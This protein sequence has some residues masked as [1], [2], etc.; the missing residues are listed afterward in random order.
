[1][2]DR[3]PAIFYHPSIGIQI[4]AAINSNRDYYKRFAQPTLMEWTRIRATQQF[5]DG[6][7]WFKIFL[8]DEEVHSVVN[9]KARTYWDMK[10]YTSSDWYP[11]QP[12]TIR[13]LVILSKGKFAR[14]NKLSINLEIQL[15]F[16]S[17]ILNLK[18][19]PGKQLR[20]ISASMSSVH[21]RKKHGKS[22]HM[23]Y[24][25]LLSLHYRN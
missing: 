11:A 22:S 4:S 25:N 9:K 1:M 16:Y 17:L 2:G 3:Q 12:G 19:L 14:H 18:P 15:I 13:N 20:P 8:N 5:V 23:F 7:F 10:V 6:Q 24:Q 21:S